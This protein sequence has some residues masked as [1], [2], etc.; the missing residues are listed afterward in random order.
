MC[1][2]VMA[3]G[4]CDFGGTICGTGDGGYGIV[5]PVMAV[6]EELLGATMTSGA[7]AGLGD[8]VVGGCVGCCVALGGWYGCF[9]YCVVPVGVIAV[10]W[11][12]VG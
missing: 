9:V 12:C 8:C 4:V 10:C 2:F 1:G 5:V 7:N 3:C 6:A 11:Y